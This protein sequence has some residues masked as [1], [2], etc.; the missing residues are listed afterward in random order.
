[1]AKKRPAPK[2]DRLTPEQAEALIRQS[3]E[4]V[5][6]PGPPE[7]VSKHD[8]APSDLVARLRAIDWFGHCGQ[9]GDFDVTMEVDLAKNWGQVNKELKSRARETAWLEAQ[10]QLSSFL[11]AHHRERDRQWNKFADKFTKA[12]TPL[13]EKVW[14]PFGERHGLEIQFLWS[15]EWSV[16][17][18][19]MENEFLDCQ[20]RAFFGLELLSVYEAGHLPCGWHGKWPQGRL[21]AF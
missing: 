11:S 10:N 16:R 7:F 1:M 18:A 20:H 9:P 17:L 19:L 14:Q 4:A 6:G 21:V 15:V 13:K 12:L 8:Y 2:K 5:F 3:D